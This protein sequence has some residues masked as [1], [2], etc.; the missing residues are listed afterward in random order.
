MLDE[1]EHVKECRTYISQ[2]MNVTQEQ[3]TELVKC[4]ILAEILEKLREIDDFN[5]EHK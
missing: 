5:R 2:H 3:N 1:F 4:I